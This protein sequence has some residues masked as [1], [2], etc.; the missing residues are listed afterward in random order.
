MGDVRERI[1][2]MAEEIFELAMSEHENK[3]WDDLSKK[4]IYE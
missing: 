2:L 1:N 3:F 4:R